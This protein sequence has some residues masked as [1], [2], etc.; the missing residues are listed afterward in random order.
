M[1]KRLVHLLNGEEKEVEV[2]DKL[3]ILDRN[4]ILSECTKTRMEGT[5]LFTDTDLFLLQ[6]RTLQKII[7]GVSLEQIDPDDCDMIFDDY[8]GIFGIGDKKKG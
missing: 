3:N 7:S 8:K 1:S 2:K 6:T 5:K 4:K